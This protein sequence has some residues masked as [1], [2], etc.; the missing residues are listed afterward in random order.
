VKQPVDLSAAAGYEEVI[1][2]LMIK[3]ADDSQR[4]AWKENSFFRRYAQNAGE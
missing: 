3:V 1:R 2:S 4:P